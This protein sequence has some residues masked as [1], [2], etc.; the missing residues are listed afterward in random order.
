M[1]FRRLLSRTPRLFVAIILGAALI[2]TSPVGALSDGTPLTSAAT[3]FGTGFDAPTSDAVVQP[4]GKIIVVGGF[5]TFNGVAVPGIVRLNSNGTLDTTFNSNV[6]TGPGNAGITAV[7]LQ[8]DGK[9][10][11]GGGFTSWNGTNV[12]RIARLLSDGTADSAFNTNIGTGIDGG[13]G[14]SAGALP[15]DIEIQS[16]GKIVIVGDFT[17]YQSSTQHHIVRLNTNGTADSA[18]NTNVSTLLD[19]YVYDV[20]LQSTGHLIITGG[21]IGNGGTTNAGIVRLTSSG[22]LDSAFATAVGTG[23][24]AVAGGFTGASAILSDDSILVGG[25]FTQFGTSNADSLA[26]LSA[27]GVIDNSFATSLT[28]GLAGSMSL[29]PFQWMDEIMVQSDNSLLISGCF[30]TVNGVSSPGIARITTAGQVDSSFGVKLGTGFNGCVRKM[31]A[32]ADGTVL[33]FG[34]FT[35]VNGT[36]ANHIAVLGEAVT[37]TTTTAPTTATTTPAVSKRSLPATGSHFAVWSLAS[38]LL[39][40]AGVALRKRGLAQ[41]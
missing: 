26:K 35:Q 19:I 5:T 1:T 22:T 38:M 32:M 9:I 7:A 25:K 30:V 17:Q 34:Q 8:A 29:T 33:A 13:V 24:A 3:K 37:T 6:G 18:F 23:A 36:T 14:S 11:L 41:N 4:D 12:G 40:T 10:V 28:A 21:N 27:T 2:H 16:D 39:L 15:D 20:A 31:L